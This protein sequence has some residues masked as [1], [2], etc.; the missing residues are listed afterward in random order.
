VSTPI[1]DFL[2]YA[3]SS[4]VKGHVRKT[5]GK[6]VPVR[7]HSRVTE[8]PEQRARE[9]AV[10]K[11][12]EIKLWRAW[13]DGGRSPN[14]LKP[15]LRSFGP[16][17]RSKSNVYKGKVKMIP[18]SA[19]EAEFQ[20]RFVDAL[21][22]YNPE[23]G[24][25]GTYVYRYLDKAK[26]FIVENQNIGRI[27]ENRV[28]KIKKYQNAKADLS[29]DLGREPTVKEIAE[30]LNWREAEAERMDSELRNDLLSQGFDE[31]PYSIIPSKSEEVI[32][33]FKY[34]L[35]GTE[36]EVY[37]YLIGS[38]KERVASTGEIAKKVNLP[39]YQVSRIKKNIQ[40]K[41]RRY[42]TE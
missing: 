16:M 25:L 18:D 33:L 15:L 32:R 24:A 21:R 5:E 31:D 7:S 23:K 36:R 26:R 4:Q 39:D 17:I 13:N 19:I 14:D 28:Y 12:K 10:R 35:E 38:G 40:K 42:L 29:E 3:K 22:S 37:E 2:K 34:E 20:L 30:R 6:T 9:L 27:P 41:L 8:D 11:Q 1:T